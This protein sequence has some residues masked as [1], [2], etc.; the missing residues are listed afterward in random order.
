MTALEPLLDE[1]RARVRVADFSALASLAPQIE[2]ALAAT[3]RPMDA[4]SLQRLKAKAD[5]NAG[6]LDA[7]RSGLRAARRRLEETRR[8]AQGLQTYDVKGRRADITPI[9]PTAG[10]F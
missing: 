5:A 10:R 9:G 8:A 1:L 7:A 2:A 4:G 3:D 6:L